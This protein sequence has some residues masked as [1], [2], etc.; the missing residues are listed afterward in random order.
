MKGSDAERLMEI[1]Q[2][3][4]PDNWG[5]DNCEEE[6]GWIK[7]GGNHAICSLQLQEAKDK[8]AEIMEIF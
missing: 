8:G 2:K 6:R 7:V 1:I 4:S 3:L 5:N